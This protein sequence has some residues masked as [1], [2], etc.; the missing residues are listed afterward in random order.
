MRFALAADPGELT[1]ADEPYALLGLP[2]AWTLSDAQVRS[3]QVRALARCHPDRHPEGAVR[4]AAMRLSARINEA[5]AALASAE[6]RAEVFVRVG[7][8]DG[9]IP[10]LPPDEL[11]EW[12]ERREWIDERRREGAS[13]LAAIAEWRRAT[14]EEILDAIR[15]AACDDSGLPRADADWGAARLS[16][17]RLRAL[18]RACGA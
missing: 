17:A 8:G 9:P 14:L 16:I 13:G 18:K 1:A 3:A 7:G 6:L 5:V 10:Q 4:E 15:R 2:R 11:M 12:M